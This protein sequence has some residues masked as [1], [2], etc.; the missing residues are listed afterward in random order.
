MGN[1]WVDPVK[2]SF[3]KKSFQKILSKDP[4]KILRESLDFSSPKESLRES[5]GRDFQD[6]L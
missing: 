2:G 1:F 3:Q 5:H 6:Y 4:L